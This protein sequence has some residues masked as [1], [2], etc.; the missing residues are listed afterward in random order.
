MECQINVYRRPERNIA[1]RIRE[2]SELLTERW[3][4]DNVPGDTER[5]LMFQDAMC[6]SLNGL[7]VS[8]IMF[9]CLDGTI[10]ISIMGTH[11]DYRGR[12]LG[13][14]LI[15]YFFTYVRNLGFEEIKVFTVPPE[16]KPSY[17][18]TVEFYEKHGFRIKKRYTELWEKGAIE[19]IKV[20]T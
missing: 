17:K 19:L 4:T 6:L 7:I 18:E 8:F 14:E 15:K 1:S 13:S 9:T 16:A 5:D 11:P 12:G 2:I 10:N 3:F 20:L